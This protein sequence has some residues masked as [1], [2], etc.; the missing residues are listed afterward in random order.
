MDS[1]KIDHDLLTRW[2][3]VNAVA[4]MAEGVPRGALLEVWTRFEWAGS[5]HAAAN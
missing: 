2:Q 1:V 4:R 5:V 3:A